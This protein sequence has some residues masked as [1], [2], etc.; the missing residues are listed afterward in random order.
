MNENHSPFILNFQY[1]IL[2]V[3]RVIINNHKGHRVKIPIQYNILIAIWYSFCLLFIGNKNH[4][5]S[6]RFSIDH[7][8]IFNI[9]TY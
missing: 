6:M 2:P 5:I 3:D 9:F 4:N 8:L 7:W 1:F